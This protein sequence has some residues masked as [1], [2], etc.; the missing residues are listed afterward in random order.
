MANP[1]P[2]Q[3]FTWLLDVYL[4][5][6]HYGGSADLAELYRWVEH[7]RSNLPPAYE[8]TVRSTLY[9]H[10][11]DS[12]AYVQGNPDVFHTLSRGS[13]KWSL[14]H[15]DLHLEDFAAPLAQA[16]ALAFALQRMSDEEIRAL[17]KRPDAFKELKRRAA[18]AIKQALLTPE[19]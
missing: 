12:S 18:N 8:E 6:R 3:D 15:I 10:S 2:S 17:R 14:R 13:G 9:R 16:R 7:H 4:A 11:S 19:K 1:K 5:M